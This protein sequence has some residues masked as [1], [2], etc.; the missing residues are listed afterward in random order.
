VSVE[1]T[2]GKR[3]YDLGNR[4]WDIPRLREMLGLVLERNSDVKDFFVEHTFP[5][6]GHRK[7]LLNAHLVQQDRPYPDAIFLAIEDV[8][9]DGGGAPP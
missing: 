6:I 9:E 5:G 4:Q 8:S 7:M 2:I 3:L 1:N